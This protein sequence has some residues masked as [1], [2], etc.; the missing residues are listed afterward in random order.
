ML[1]NSPHSSFYDYTDGVL[2][3]HNIIVDIV[4]DFKGK[5]KNGS[6]MV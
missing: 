4:T 1:I 5:D 3:Y 6:D 2:D